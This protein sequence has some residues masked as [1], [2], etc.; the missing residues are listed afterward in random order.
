MID[1]SLVEVGIEWFKDII[2]T[3]TKWFQ[4]GLTDGYDA[5]TSKIFGTPIPETGEAF[6]FGTPTN[7]PWIAIHDALVT[8][9][10]MMV[11]LL[12]LV[13]S[14]QGRHAVNIFNFGSGFEA[15]RTKKVAWTGAFLIVTW[16]WIAS[17]SLYLVDA[18]TLALIPELGTLLNAMVDFLTSTVTNPMLGFLLA[19]I[20][21]L[22]MWT[23]QALLFL[24]RILLIVFVYGMPI[25]I[26]LAFGN[27]P[28]LSR[29]AKTVCTKFVPLLVMPIPIAVLFSGYELLFHQ[30]T[31]AVLAPGVPFLQHIVAVSLPLISLVIIWKLF[32]YTTPMASKAIKTTAG[33]TFKAGAI[34]GAGY[35][36]GPKVAGTAARWGTKAAAG[37]ALAQRAGNATSGSSLTRT[38]K[39]HAGGTNQDSIATDAYGQ[40]GV[41][42]YRRTEN[43]PGY[44]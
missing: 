35:V 14:V 4:K 29:I 1:I 23:L 26:A 20:G 42:A 33:M 31:D 8:G 37:Q 16:Y 15:R 28:I 18:I 36:A 5:L 44:Y 34:L 24:R 10:V 6:V 40:S 13:I 17:V 12:L 43:D 3:V 22:S 21:G 11:A 39:D 32:S 30:G 19:G 41:S 9:E 7:E 25:G 2:G 38:S 27:L